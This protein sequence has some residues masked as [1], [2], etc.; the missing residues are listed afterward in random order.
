MEFH[1]ILHGLIRIE[2]P[3]LEPLFEALLETKEVHRLRNMRQMNFDVPLI[4]ELG[5]S[6]RL[7]HSIGV[8]NIA[9][10]LARKSHLDLDKTKILLSAALLHDAAIPP[11]GHLIE[12][13]FK[14]IDP[15]FNHENILKQLIYGRKYEELMPGE[16]AGAGSNVVQRV[17]SEHDISSA[18]VLELINPANDH[19]SPISADIDID[20]IDNV[21]RMA[22]MLGWPGAKRNLNQLLS[23]TKLIGLKRLEFEESAE[24][25]LLKWLDY[26][27]K[28]YTMIIAHKQCIPQNALQ[29]DICRLAVRN[30]VITPKDWTVTEPIF[31]ENLRAHESTKYLADQL[32]SGCKYKLIDYLWLKDLDGTKKF[33][34]AAITD[35]LK[36]IAHEVKD[37]LSLFVWFE[38]GLIS[39]QVRWHSTSGATKRLG[40]NSNSCMIALIDPKGRKAPRI[41]KHAILEWRQ[42]TLSKFRKVTY[43]NAGR[44][45]DPEDYTGDFFAEKSDEFEF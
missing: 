19:T 14:Q 31:E 6:R 18:E 15:N 7:P 23:K 13:E 5:R 38:R 37:D 2:D 1:D 10:Q 36:H 4:Q 44:V 24:K 42:K 9:L 17:F 8:A 40:T 34:N 3:R 30:E 43:L 20:N 35:R 33:T 25:N 27:Q 45:C 11:F 41:T 32:V 26:R 12:S 28:I 29:A 16:F 39:R 21:H 22:A